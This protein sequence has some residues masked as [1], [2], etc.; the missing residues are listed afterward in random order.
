MQ[1]LEAAGVHAGQRV[2]IHAGAGG[3][4]TFAVQLAK[5][6][7]AHVVT[8]A[9]PRNVDFVQKVPFCIRHSLF[10]AATPFATVSFRTVQ[11][12]SE[13]VSLAVCPARSSC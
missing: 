10:R 8:T 4:G 6:R 12:S 11:H 3:V 2:L 9:G 5:A 13:V 1:A 7:G